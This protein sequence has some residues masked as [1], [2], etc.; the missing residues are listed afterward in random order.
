MRRPRRRFLKQRNNI[1]VALNEREWSREGVLPSA[2]HMP[3]RVVDAPPTRSRYVL[4]NNNTLIDS[5]Y[6]IL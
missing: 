4:H 6:D 5:L 2:P 1:V 3:R